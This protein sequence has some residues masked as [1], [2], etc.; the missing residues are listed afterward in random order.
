M[1]RILD[2]KQGLAKGRPVFDI[3]ASLTNVLPT[4]QCNRPREAFA[5]A[6]KRSFEM[7]SSRQPELGPG[8]P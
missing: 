8:G 4:M 3:A 2:E 1:K 7:T 5:E 6:M